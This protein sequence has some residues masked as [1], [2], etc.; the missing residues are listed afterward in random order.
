MRKMWKIILSACRPG[1]WILTGGIQMELR[2]KLMSAAVLGALSV[3]AGPAAAGGFALGTQS[4]SGT[5][6][7]FA[8]GAAVAD[9]ASVAWSNPAGMSLL[10]A[11]KQVAGVLHAIRPSF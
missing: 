11:G 1:G 9:D 3:A 6:N 4:G 5:G 2:A 10:P 8:G 7:A